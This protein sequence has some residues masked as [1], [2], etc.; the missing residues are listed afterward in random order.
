M[1]AD[2]DERATAGS[3]AGEPTSQS[4]NPAPT[5]VFEVEFVNLTEF[6]A[7]DFSFGGGDVGFERPHESD[8]HR[9]IALRLGR[10]DA[11]C[12]L[13]R[14]AS[15]FLTEYVHAGVE[16]RDGTLGETRSERDHDPSSFS[17]SV[18]RS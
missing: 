7:V 16:C 8:H 1:N 3:L 15:D 9:R 4:G 6:S 10:G 2:V 17:A 13:D 12:V 11:L 14:L 18:L 5:H